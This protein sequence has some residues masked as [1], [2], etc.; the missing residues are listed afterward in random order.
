MGVTGSTG[1]ITQGKEVGDMD[2]PN[3][4]LAFFSGPVANRRS[5]S[6]NSGH[7]HMGTDLC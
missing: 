7:L 6:G 3:L 4:R 1:S 5:S 2:F